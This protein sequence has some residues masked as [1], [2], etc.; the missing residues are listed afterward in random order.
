MKT[1]DIVLIPFPFSEITNVKIRPAA[2]VCLTKDSYKDLVLCAISSTLKLPLKDND[3]MLIPDDVNQL[4]TSSTLKVDRIF[5]AKREQVVAKIGSLNY[6][7]L[8]QFKD[9]FRALID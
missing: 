6:D 8:T 1:G 3:M 5:T 4:K 7:D 9:I 2:L